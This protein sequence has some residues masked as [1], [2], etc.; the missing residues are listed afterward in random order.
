MV[1]KALIESGVF[2]ESCQLSLYR[3]CPELVKMHARTI[4]DLFS[5]SKLIESRSIMEKLMN[6]LIILL[7]GIPGWFIYKSGSKTTEMEL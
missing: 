6:V 3:A 2:A 4:H 1:Y 5:I 7:V